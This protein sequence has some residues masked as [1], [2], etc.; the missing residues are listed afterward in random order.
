MRGFPSNES[1]ER[2]YLPPPK[3]LFYRYIGSSSVKR[4]KISIDM[5]LIVTSVGDELLWLLTSMTL[6][7]F[8]PSLPRIKGFGELQHETN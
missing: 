4:L 5:L 2:E 8:E 1:V 6:N 7:D 3:K